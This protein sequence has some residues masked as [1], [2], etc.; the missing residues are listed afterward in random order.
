MPAKPTRKYA[1]ARNERG[2]SQISFW[3]SRE[4]RQKLDEIKKSYGLKNRGDVMRTLLERFERTGLDGTV[5]P[6]TNQQ[7]QE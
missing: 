5:V 1:E 6:A 4:Q 3:V 2:E 7:P